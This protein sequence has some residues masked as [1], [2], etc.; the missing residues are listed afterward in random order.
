MCFG[1]EFLER[2]DIANPRDMKGPLSE[3]AGEF[4]QMKEML[5]AVFG[6]NI[7]DGRNRAGLHD[8]E[9]GP[10]VEVGEERAVH[11]VEIDVLAAG[12]RDHAGDFGV[13]QRAE[14]SD[15]A[16][17]NPDA[18]QEFG[19]AELCGHDAGLAENAGADDAADDHHDGGEK[20]ESGQKARGFIEGGWRGGQL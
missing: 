15:H 5:I 20:A 17:Q 2:G 1:G 13:G 3:R 16:G 4:G 9:D 19:R 8:G 7:S 10:A 6:E 12:F 11:A 14:E 18:E